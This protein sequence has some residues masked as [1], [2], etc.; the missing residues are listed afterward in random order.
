[1]KLLLEYGANI[2]E[3]NE[4]GDIPK[5]MAFKYSLGKVFPFLDDYQDL[6]E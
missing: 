1:M 5:D 4:D 3:K 2:N 6:P